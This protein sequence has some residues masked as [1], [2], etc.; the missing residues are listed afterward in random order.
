LGFINEELGLEINDDWD[1]DFWIILLFSEFEDSIQKKIKKKKNKYVK[2]I[3]V[4][5]KLT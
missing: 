3:R 2:T 4:K 1:W 5:K